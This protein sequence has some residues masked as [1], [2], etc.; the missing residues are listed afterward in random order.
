MSFNS[1]ADNL[2]ADL[3]FG[4][5]AGECNARAQRRGG[6]KILFIFLCVMATLRLCVSFFHT[7]FAI[8]DNLAADLVFGFNAG[9]CNARAQRRGIA[10]VFFIFFASWRPCVFAFFLS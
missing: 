9:E 8:I 5:N 2:A 1:T 3:V 10:K 4:F 6:A 7:P